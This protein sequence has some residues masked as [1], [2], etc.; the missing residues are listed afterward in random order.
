MRNATFIALAALS[1]TLASACHKPRPASVA[2]PTTPA[3]TKLP[4]FTLKDVN[5]E[6]HK[7]SD[8]KGK[9]LLLNWFASW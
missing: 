9:V 2:R 6:A 4:D 5:G 1:V 7:L 3:V 8:F